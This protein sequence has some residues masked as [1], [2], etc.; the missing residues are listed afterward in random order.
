VTTQPGY[1]LRL[2]RNRLGITTR[3]V[4][5][6]SKN[7]ALSQ[8]NRELFVSHTRLSQIDNGAPSPG[9]HKLLSLSA[10]YGVKIDDLLGLYA[11]L[12]SL[13]KH[14]TPAA[15]ATTHPV[16]LE[17]AA[18]PI[19]LD[20]AFDPEITA[21]LPAPACTATGGATAAGPRKL[22]VDLR[23]G[24]V[25]L[26]DYTLYPLLRPGSFVLIDPRQRKIQNP[27][28]ASEFDRPIYFIATRSAYFCSWCELDEGRLVVLHHP[29]SQCQT[30]HPLTWLRSPTS[31]DILP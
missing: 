18:F 13:A 7:I 29:L 11:N 27:R 22:R 16:E 31:K 20:P 15:L 26:R 4:E 6:A 5:D 10:I 30:P 25:G 19:R 23:Y 14:Q 1:Q 21:L 28:T 9:I 12:D 8:G 3:A 17:P 2:I 24:Y